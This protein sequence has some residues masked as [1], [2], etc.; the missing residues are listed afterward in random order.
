MTTPTRPGGG[1]PAAT[2]SILER[3]DGSAVLRLRGDVAIPTARAIYDRVRAVARRRDVRSVVL[4]FAA[5]R[6]LDS[7]G[8]AVVSLAERV[9]TRNGKKFALENVDD[10]HRAALELVD[11]DSLRPIEPVEEQ[12]WL[13]RFGELVL[14]AG[15]GIAAAADLVADTARELAR[16]VARKAR[17]PAGALATQVVRMGTDAIFIVALMSFLLGTSLAFQ[18][19]V[20]L[21]K[22]GAGVYTADLIGVSFVREF[23]PVI[24]AIIMTGRTGAAIAAELGTMR[25]R[26]EIDAL[27]VMGV[28]PVRY[29]IVPRITSITFVQPAL[30]LMAMFVGVAGAMLVSSLMLELGPQAFWNRMVMRLDLWDFAHG[31]GKALAFAWIIG[32]TGSV[33]GLRARADANSVGSATTRTVVI[34]VFLIVLVDAIFATSASLLEANR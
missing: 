1:L 4:D 21:E 34:S 5:V 32:F 13:E 26:S 10:R 12:R 25:V 31:L 2:G 28:S 17:L 20:Q 9:V 8:V 23:G 15:A 27:T 3:R 14:T 24:T 7:A 16:V 22:L 19:A 30:S 18:S 29:L 6:R 33:L 11:P